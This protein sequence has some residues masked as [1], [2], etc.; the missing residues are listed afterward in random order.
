[1]EFALRSAWLSANPWAASTVAGEREGALLFPSLGPS[2]ERR[3]RA[4]HLAEA[5]RLAAGGQFASLV[6]E[7]TVRGALELLKHVQTDV[8]VTRALVNFGAQWEA[9]VP[10]SVERERR[11]TPLSPQGHNLLL[12]VMLPDRSPDHAYADAVDLP[13]LTRAEWAFLLA[14]QMLHGMSPDDSDDVCSLREFV[15]CC[16]VGFLEGSDARGGHLLERWRQFV[17]RFQSPIF[18]PTANQKIYTAEEYAGSASAAAE[19]E[20]EFM[21]AV[22]SYPYPRSMQAWERATE[23]TVPAGGAP[24]SQE[25]RTFSDF[26]RLFPAP[27]SSPGGGGDWTLPEI[28]KLAVNFFAKR[29]GL[30]VDEWTPQSVLT[31]KAGEE[32]VL[33]MTRV[34]QTELDLFESWDVLEVF[35]KR[36]GALQCMLVGLSMREM[37]EAVEEV[38]QE[39]GNTKTLKKWAVADTSHPLVM[40]ALLKGTWQSAFPMGTP[41]WATQRVLEKLHAERFLVAP[42]PENAVRVA[43]RVDTRQELSS[44]RDN[45]D[46][47]SFLLSEEGIDTYLTRETMTRIRQLREGKLLST[48]YG[49]EL[50]DVRSFAKA[51]GGIPLD[52]WYEWCDLTGVPGARAARLAHQ[53]FLDM[54]TKQWRR[55]VQVLAETAFLAQ[56]GQWISEMY[57]EEAVHREARAQGERA[58]R[59]SRFRCALGRWFTTQAVSGGSAFSKNA[60][61]PESALVL[62]VHKRTGLWS[63]AKQSSGDVWPVIIVGAEEGEEQRVRADLSARFPLVGEPGFQALRARRIRERMAREGDAV[64]RALGASGL[65]RYGALV[66]QS[67]VLARSLVD[68]TKFLPKLLAAEPSPVFEVARPGEPGETVRDALVPRPPGPSVAE[69]YRKFLQENKPELLVEKGEPEAP[70]EERAPTLLP[71]SLVL[72]ED[73]HEVEVAYAD[74]TSPEFISEVPPA[75]APHNWCTAA[76]QFLRD[77]PDFDLQSAEG[78]GLAR[79]HIASYMTSVEK[80]LRVVEAP[81]PLPEDPPLPA[82]VEAEQEQPKK[83]GPMKKK[84]KVAAKAG[85]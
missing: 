27:S 65:A 31:Q 73:T 47:A 43:A 51:L 68:A 72:R 77:T 8:E 41:E 82:L 49:A 12:D 2:T 26:V 81:P 34:R 50:R 38:V 75:H 29:L 56:R 46:Y 45:A 67:S 74:A 53:Q 39:G 36:A 3:F 79:M 69:T 10:E 76:R 62:G 80:A 83:D 37:D 18:T 60:A 63:A 42:S 7:V 54:Y 28:Q 58:A 48:K 16:A 71:S 64:Q 17:P 1:M 23:T 14:P 44:L 25:K 85:A 30:K 61:P 35:F 78:R 15:C 57:A 21:Q 66:H 32:A 9:R 24:A 33:A 70:P 13:R 5:L 19:A 40:E 84:R 20:R 52:A 22:M 6:G 59:V 55:D 11:I 4:V